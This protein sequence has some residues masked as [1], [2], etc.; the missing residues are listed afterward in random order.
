MNKSR[1]IIKGRLTRFNDYVSLLNTRNVEDISDLKLKLRLNKTDN[2]LLE[3]NEVQSQIEM[4]SS[5][6]DDSDVDGFESSFYSLMPLAQHILE[7]RF[8]AQEGEG[9]FH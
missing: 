2:L 4:H 9:S 3:F 8:E 1:G 7:S 6:E 5:G